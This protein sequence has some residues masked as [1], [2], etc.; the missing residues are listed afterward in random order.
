MSSNECS[1]NT[2]PNY[3]LLSSRQNTWRRMLNKTWLQNIQKHAQNTCFYGS[4]EHVYKIPVTF[5][6]GTQMMSVKQAKPKSKAKAYG[7]HTAIV[8][9]EPALGCLA[10]LRCPS[11]VWQTPWR[12]AS[13]QEGKLRNPKFRNDL[14]PL[15]ETRT[16]GTVGQLLNKVRNKLWC[17]V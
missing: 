5:F 7:S 8:G 14:T 12:R 15:S 3:M 2:N 13:N 6:I 17:L 9:S 1:I 16:V 10:P 11:L 4:S